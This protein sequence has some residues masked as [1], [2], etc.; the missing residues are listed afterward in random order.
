[1][2]NVF[3]SVNITLH[4]LSLSFNCARLHGFHFVFRLVCLCFLQTRY[5]SAVQ[6]RTNNMLRDFMSK[7]HRY[8]FCIL[9][10]NK[11]FQKQIS[12]YHLFFAFNKYIYVTVQFRIYISLNFHSILTC[13]LRSE[14]FEMIT[15]SGK[16]FL[17][18]PCWFET[19]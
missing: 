3:P 12:Q 16:V 17:N 1:M 9:T 19:W 7:F 8:L 6:L 15:C 5:T 11:F 10:A 13:L 18:S 2:E 4:N 14:S